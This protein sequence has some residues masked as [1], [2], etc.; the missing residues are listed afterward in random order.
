M[1]G[2]TMGVFPVVLPV[3]AEDSQLCGFYYK[4]EFPEL[5]CL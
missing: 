2:L 5:I 4:Q 3:N 1:L